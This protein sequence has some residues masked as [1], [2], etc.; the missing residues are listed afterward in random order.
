MDYQTL[1]KWNV[2]QLRKYADRQGIAIPLGITKMRM[3]EEILRAEPSENAD[4]VAEDAAVDLAEEK[5]APKRRGRKPKAAEQEDAALRPAAFEVDGEDAPKPIEDERIVRL[6]DALRSEMAKSEQAPQEPKPRRVGRPKK[7]D[8]PPPEEAEVTQL[9]MDMVKSEAEKPKAASVP[10][11][12]ETP[13]EAQPDTEETAPQ[14]PFKSSAPRRAENEDA[15]E[16]QQDNSPWKDYDDDGGVLDIHPEGYGFLRSDGHDIYVSAV[17]IRRFNL[18]N[19]D[20]IY[21]KTRPGREGD[22]GSALVR[23]ATINDLTLEENRRRV[24]FDELKP[25]YP[26]ERLRLEG[27]GDNA[28]LALRVID[29]V[30]P[31]GKGQ[32]GLIVA[33]PKAGKT[34]LLKK[35]ANAISRNYPEVTVYILLIDERPEEVTDI[36]RTTKAQV[37]H[38]TF[39]EVPEN[40]VRVAETTLDKAKRLVEAGKDV[41]ILLDSITRL[42]RAYNLTV[43][44]TGRTLSGGLDVGSLHKPKYFLGAAR[45]TE[46]G[47]SLTIIA[48][49]LVE[50]GSRMDEIIYEEFKGTGN[51]EIHLDRSLSERRIFPAIDLNKSGTRKEELLMRE[52]EL[53]SV[54]ALRRLLADIGNQEATEQI[55]SLL[56]KTQNNAEFFK[57]IRDWIAAFQRKGYSNGRY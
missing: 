37:F 9:S 2:V 46:N 49:A 50:T 6:L 32:R 56:Q 5:A 38:S 25:L 24:P 23:I 16:A 20:V 27:A 36:V 12:E 18:R 55:L 44:P 57:K 8:A 43:P 42:A 13:R 21:G 29:I 35:I 17:Q 33:Q 26:M 54:N 1:M 53:E 19:G 47:G 34:V 41:V 52:D 4:V 51:M 15:D 45:N 3:I 22:R 10:R 31:I 7:K 40:H 39:D 28:D 30:A 11:L 14:Y 48:T